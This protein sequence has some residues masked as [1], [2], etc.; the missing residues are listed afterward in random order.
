MQLVYGYV[1]IVFSL[2]FLD[3]FVMKEI[4]VFIF[5]LAIQPNPVLLQGSND[6]NPNIPK[7]PETFFLDASHHLN[8]FEETLLFHNHLFVDKTMFIEELI[9]RQQTCELISRPSR[10]A[11][12]F[13]M[14][15]AEAFFDIPHHPNGSVDHCKRDMVKSFFEGGSIIVLPG[16]K[17]SIE[18]KP[19]EI[20]KV[21]NAMEEMGRHPTISISLV[22]DGDTFNDF[23]RKFADQISEIISTKNYASFLPKYCRGTGLLDRCYELLNSTKENLAGKLSTLEHSIEILTGLLTSH[24]YSET[25]VLIDEHDYPLNRMLCNE[26]DFQQTANFLK[27]LFTWTYKGKTYTSI[28]RS[29]VT[30]V[31]QLPRCEIS[32]GMASC[33]SSS[34]LEPQ[35][36]PHFGFTEQNVRTLL[37]K[38]PS[39]PHNLTE[40]KTWYGGYTF[41]EHYGYNPRSIRGYFESNQ[42]GNYWITSV[43]LGLNSSHLDTPL[44]QLFM[45][46]KFQRCVQQLFVSNSPLRAALS[47][48]IHYTN[49][50]TSCRDTFLSAS[51]AMGYTTCEQISERYYNVRIPNKEVRDE[52]KHAIRLWTKKHLKENFDAIMAVVDQILENLKLNNFSSVQSNFYK[53]LSVVKE[54][55]PAK[56]HCDLIFGLLVQLDDNWHLERSFNDVISTCGQVEF[57][58]YITLK[59]KLDSNCKDSTPIAVNI[60]IN[61]NSTI[62]QLTTVAQTAGTSTYEERAV[63]E[64]TTNISPSTSIKEPFTKIQMTDDIKNKIMECSKKRVAQIEEKDGRKYKWYTCVVSGPKIVGWFPHE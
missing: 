5:L 13:N 60:V 30:G 18:T 34:V 39:F 42:T 36:M 52:F 43:P 51:T 37:E 23:I 16:N 62:E 8:E 24:F 19:L 32:S 29:V 49:A 15:M 33:L 31:L 20:S 40:L 25:V 35:Y 55:T 6:L 57:R 50:V 11:K 22:S 45:L 14:A 28:Y 41:G 64:Q 48:E 3:L 44:H 47:S 58:C 53:L 27:N 9:R 2:G 63:Q 1:G 10:W 21:E 54:T 12:T 38:N 59:L 46:D 7:S 61:G 26:T 17:S 4:V 56:L